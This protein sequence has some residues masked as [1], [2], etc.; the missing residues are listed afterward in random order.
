MSKPVTESQNYNHITSSTQISAK[1]AAILGIFC[2]SASSTPTITVYDNTAGSGTI[3]VNTFTPNA[4][5]FYPMP[6]RTKTGLYVAI[7]GTVDCTVFWD[8]SL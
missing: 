7:S 8:N 5:S 6:A 4:A 1:P 2:A 3:L